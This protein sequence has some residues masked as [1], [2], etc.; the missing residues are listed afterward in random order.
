MKGFA[1]L[2][3]VSGLC[4]SAAHAETVTLTKDDVASA[5]DIQ[6]AIYRATHF[7]TIAG[8]VIFDGS[9]GKFV[10]A[11]SK[12]DISIPVSNLELVGTHGATIAT[13]ETGLAFFDESVRNVL[14][15]GM[16]FECRSFGDM[17]LGV[18]G[19]GVR[20]VTIRD[21]V[22]DID[23]I[24]V[25]IHG[26]SGWKFHRNVIKATTFDAEPAH[27]MELFQVKDSEVI[28]NSLTA[29]FGLR[30]DSETGVPSSANK[31]VGNRVI[32]DWRGIFLENATLNT[33]L[34]NYIT[35][36]TESYGTA[37]GLTGQSSRNRVQLNKA[38]ITTGGSLSTVVDEGTDNKVSGNSP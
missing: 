22:F 3:V 5:R 9:K 29:P 1:F 34:L 23:G 17:N 12:L 33:V 32:A 7:G 20:D 30:L 18:A 8:K 2:L 26:G 21:N 28:G 31:I 4:V 36:T 27:A 35:L 25:F 13:C 15:E 16:R 38:T 6:W 14:V 11:G 19:G 24:G 10:S 37:I